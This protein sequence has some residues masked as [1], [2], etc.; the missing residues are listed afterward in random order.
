MNVSISS[1]L[2]DKYLQQKKSEDAQN[3]YWL[4]QTEDNWQQDR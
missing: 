3:I 4:N 1:L 2:Y